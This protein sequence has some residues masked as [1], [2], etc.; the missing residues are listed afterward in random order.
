MSSTSENHYIIVLGDYSALSMWVAVAKV[1]AWSYDGGGA[2][3]EALSRST[4]DWYPGGGIEAD[5][6]EDDWFAE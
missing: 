3:A 2:A 6:G 4:T 1:T 5:G